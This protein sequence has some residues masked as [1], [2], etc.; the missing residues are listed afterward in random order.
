MARIMGEK[1]DATH[2]KGIGRLAW[3][4]LLDNC[5][6]GKILRTSQNFRFPTAIYH[7]K[8]TIPK[9]GDTDS[10]AASSLISRTLQISFFKHCHKFPPVQNTSESSPYNQSQKLSCK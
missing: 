4:F 1:A 3:P 8:T 2:R 10:L 9:T 5:H 7:M 6:E